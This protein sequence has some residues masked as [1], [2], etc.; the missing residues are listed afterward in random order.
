MRNSLAQLSQPA[1]GVAMTLLGAFLFSLMP[2]WVRA[3]QPPFAPAMVFYRALIGSTAMALL[4]LSRET[5]RLQLRR[6]FGQP[7]LLAL[8]AGMGICMGTST[9]FYFISLTHTTVAKALLLSY[10]SPLYVALLSPLVLKEPA[11]RLTWAALALGL[12]G[13]ACTTEPQLLLTV[14]SHETIGILAG[15]LSGMGFGGV[16]LIGRYLAPHVSSAVRVMAG[17]IVVSLIMLPWMFQTSITF[18]THNLLWLLLLGILCMAIPFT[19]FFHGQAYI[20]AQTSALISLFEPACGIVIS[21]AAFGETLSPLA[22]MGAVL[23]LIS[24]YLA[25]RA[26]GA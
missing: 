20:P 26:A 12:T 25:G 4:I 22:G 15:I 16:F 17:G 13:I 8:L 6:L 19:L 10:T 23:I 18:L 1:R 11:R 2:L 9:L 14:Q 3:I 5:F 7:R 24:T 21:Y